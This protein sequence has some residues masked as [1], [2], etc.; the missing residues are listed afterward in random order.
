LFISGSN[1]LQTTIAQKPNSAVARKNN[2]LPPLKQAQPPSTT[3]VKP[4][5][6]AWPARELADVPLVSVLNSQEIEYRRR[7][8]E[9]REKI[10]KCLTRCEDLFEY[11]DERERR[12]TTSCRWLSRTYRY[13]GRPHV[14]KSKLS[15]YHIYPF[16]L[17]FAPVARESASWK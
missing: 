14:V 13:S 1:S 10:T 12:R 3:M 6:A 7:L 8:D 4:A 2:A 5:T 9:M 16:Y 11:D 17:E 15:F